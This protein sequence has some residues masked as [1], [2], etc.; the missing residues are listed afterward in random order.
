MKIVNTKT[1]VVST[2]DPE[3]WAE[4]QRRPGL[5]KA[6]KV[7]EVPVPPEALAILKKKAQKEQTT[8]TKE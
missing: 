4:I 1:G 5:L 3:Q 7:L 6:F 2:I 8:L